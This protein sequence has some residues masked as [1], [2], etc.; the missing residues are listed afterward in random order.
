VLRV[1]RA[2]LAA[3]FLLC[4]CPAQ[5]GGTQGPPLAFPNNW[6]F[7]NDAQPAMQPI[8]KVTGGGSDSITVK[9][10]GGP[11]CGCNSMAASVKLTTP[12]SCT[13]TLAFDWESD[14]DPNDLNS[15]SLDV[16]FLSG[17]ATSTPNWV[18][19][20]YLGSTFTGHSNCAVRTN[21]VFP[22]HPRLVQGH[23][24]IKLAALDPLID[25]ACTKAFDTIEFHVQFYGCDPVDMTATLAHLSLSP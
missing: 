9:G 19:D 10:T 18:N 16:R 6:T 15:T 22:K 11:D 7:T 20:G 24:V 17:G 25:G 23:N 5:P 21:N 14:G 12:V 13:A 2:F 8:L 1:R 4:A 3:A